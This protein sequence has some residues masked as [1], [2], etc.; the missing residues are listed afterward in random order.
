VTGICLKYK[1]NKAAEVGRLISGLGKLS[2]GVKITSATEEPATAA[3]TAEVE[4][5]EAPVQGQAAAV[6]PAATPAA[7][8]GGG[9]GGK[10]KKG[11]G[12]K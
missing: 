2:A 9:G 3:T 6:V 10:K 1:T 7:S 5:T 11:K 4:M 12:K 8:G